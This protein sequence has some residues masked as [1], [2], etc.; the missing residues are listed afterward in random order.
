LC[1]IAINEIENAKVSFQKMILI[2]SGIKELNSAEIDEEKQEDIFDD[3]CLRKFVIHK[4]SQSE[5]YVLDAA[6]MLEPF[7]GSYEWIIETVKSSTMVDILGHLEISKALKYLQQKHFV[8]G[9]ETLKAFEKMSPKMNGTAANNLSFITFLQGDMK[10]AEKYADLA[11][12]DDRYNSKA[13]TNKGNCYFAKNEYEKAK[14]IYLDA[15]SI[16]A[17]CIEAQ[18]NLGLVNK[19]LGLYNEALA[20]FEKLHQVLQNNSQ[21]IFNIAYM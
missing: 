12:M 18:F 17:F 20:C 15:I 7:L 9:I 1:Y 11:M 4:N 10:Q 3:D 21:V 14:E 16:D 6:K 2:E 13:V 5:K 8:Q 19:E